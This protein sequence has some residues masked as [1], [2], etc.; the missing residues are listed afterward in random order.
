MSVDDKA[1]KAYLE[2]VREFAE[3]VMIPSKRTADEE[4]D[5]ETPKRRSS[6]KAATRIPSGTY[7]LPKEVL[8]SEE[9]RSF[10]KPST[11]PR[12]NNSRRGSSSKA[13][14]LDR[15]KDVVE[16]LDDYVEEKAIPKSMYKAVRSLVE[17][18]G[19]LI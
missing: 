4:L 12:S 16:L 8:S 18:I 17:S 14:V 6:R 11:S 3:S 5:P 10:A 19:T 13:A 2:G 15:I 9:E 1:A 7:T